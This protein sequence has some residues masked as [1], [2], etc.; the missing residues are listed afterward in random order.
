M[1]Q[2]HDPAPQDEGFIELAP[3]TLEAIKAAGKKFDEDV[4]AGRAISGS[5]RWVMGPAGDRFC[6]RHS[7]PKPEPEVAPE[8]RTWWWRLL[9]WVLP[10]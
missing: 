4:K 8:P 2:N 5:S 7:G 3:G 9:S 6:I 1:Q 10:D